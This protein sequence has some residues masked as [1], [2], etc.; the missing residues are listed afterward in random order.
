[1]SDELTTVFPATKQIKIKDETITLTPIKFGQL[2]QALMIV[3]RIGSLIVEHGKAGTI[4]EPTAML[5]IAALGGE[6]LIHLVAFGIGKERE[7]FNTLE[8][9]EGLEL[10]VGFIEVNLDFFTK[11]VLPLLNQKAEELNSK[12]DL[13]I[14]H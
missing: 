11:R 1:M 14:Q 9:D 12:I 6:D 8:Q 2:P 4:A 5:E 13:V 3:Q 10:L 7:Y